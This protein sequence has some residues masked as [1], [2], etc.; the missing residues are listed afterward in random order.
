MY[1]IW[2][3]GALLLPTDVTHDLTF[4]VEVERW[5]ST[6]MTREKQKRITFFKKIC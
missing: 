2:L 4:R 1:P 3:A 5:C 6:S